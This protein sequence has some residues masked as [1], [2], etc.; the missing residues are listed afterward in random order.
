MKFNADHFYCIGSSHHFCEDFASSS[1]SE[2]GTKAFAIVSDGCSSAKDS[3]IGAMLLTKSA[4]Q[5]LYPVK[6]PK[7]M[8]NLAMQSANVFRRTIGVSLEAL[9]ATLLTVSITEQGFCVTNTGDGVIVA[10]NKNTNEL[11]IIEMIYES[12][13]PFYPI[14]AL[15]QADCDTYLA[16][17]PGNYTTRFYN[18]G[19]MTQEI[20]L[21][22][23]NENGM[24]PY[25]YDFSFEKYDLV[26]V[27]SDGAQSFYKNINVSIPMIE[28]IS[29]MFAFKNVQPN[30]VKRRMQK[31]FKAFDKLGYNHH[32]DFSMGVVACHD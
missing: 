15:T 3:Q 31:A 7:E 25:S 14:Y 1:V 16:Q 29:E 11:T 18:N 22:L 32:D 17:F 13:A 21:P 23:S 9:R 4:E 6:N 20:K 5:H 26:G 30:F 8:V 28:I 10:R 12:G 24:K 19:I 27:I 2:D